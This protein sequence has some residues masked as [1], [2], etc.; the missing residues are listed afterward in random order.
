MKQAGRTFNALLVNTVVGY[1]LEQCKTDPCV[2]RLMKDETVILMVAVHVDDLFVVG[3]SKEVADFYDALNNKFLTNMVGELSWYTGCTFER[4]F[5]DGTIKMSQTAFVE[6]LLKRFENHCLTK[7][8]AIPANPLIELGPK[9]EED[10]G[11]KWPHQ[12]AVGSLLWLSNMT[13]R[14]IANAVRVVARHGHNPG[15]EHWNAVLKILSYL[16]GT[17]RRGL[18]FTR[19]QGLGV[20]EYEDDDYAQKAN[21][22]RLVSGAAVMC[23]GA[24]VYVGSQR[25]ERASLRLLRKAEYVA[26]GME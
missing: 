7:T 10:P 23:G 11:G 15:E 14:D 6:E 21:D 12:E 20:S 18:T 8:S 4:N 1:G 2:L 5:K 19:G 3:R 22:R 9:T 24:C 25:R 16:R 13:R 17:K 26:C